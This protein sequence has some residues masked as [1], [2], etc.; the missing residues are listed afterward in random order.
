MAYNVRLFG[1][2]GIIQVNQR[3]VKQYN[4][5]SV[6]LNEEPCL[7]SQVI[8]V[9]GVAAGSTVVNLN[10]DPTTIVCVE[11]PDNQQIRYEV[12]PQGPM[13]TNART[14]GNGSRRASGFFNLA[15]NPGYTIS[16]ID[17]A[18]LP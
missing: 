2:Q 15:W 5:D 18:G 7:W 16:L 17:A 1:Y 14:A 4:S 3:M 6:F 11:V 10:P 12:Q 8:S 13:A 9:S